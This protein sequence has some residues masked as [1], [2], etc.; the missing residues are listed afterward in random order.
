L[1]S[2]GDVCPEKS[3]KDTP[4]NIPKSLMNQRIALIKQ[5]DSCSIYD[6]INAVQQQEGVIG[7]IFY[8]DGPTSAPS[9]S[10]P[11]IKIPVFK[12]NKEQGAELMIKVAESEDPTKMVRVTMLPSPGSFSGGWQIAIIVI[13]AIL[14]A[15]FLVSGEYI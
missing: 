1:Y 14:A 8:V 9:P 13:G 10:K 5:S 11:G 15:S 6:Q 4:S 7:A 3:P 2:P 12:I